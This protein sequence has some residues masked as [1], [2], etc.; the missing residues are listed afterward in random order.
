MRDNFNTCRKEDVAAGVV[1]VSMRIDD[2]RDRLADHRLDLVQNRLAIVGKLRV[3]DH[4]TICREEDCSVSPTAG[5]HIKPVRD[6]LDRAD[7]PE[8]GATTAPLSTGALSCLLR[9]DARREHYEPDGHNRSQYQQPF[10]ENLP[11]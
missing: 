3:D 7:R 4:D 9:D 11:I 6:F 8:T 2:E 1:A 10:H 5:N